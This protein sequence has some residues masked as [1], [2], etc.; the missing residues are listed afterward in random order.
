MQV[1]NSRNDIKVIILTKLFNLLFDCSNNTGGLVNALVES[2]P[3]EL[4]QN[5]QL[6][7]CVI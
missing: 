6:K 5:S 1:Q 7:V 4:E 2:S 3:L